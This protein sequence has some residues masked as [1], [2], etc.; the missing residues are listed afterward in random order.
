M[1]VAS[2]AM[3]GVDKDGKLLPWDADPSQYAGH[4]RV[5]A[6]WLPR[7]ERFAR[8]FAQTEPAK[9]QLD[10][11]RFDPVGQHDR[12]VRVYEADLIGPG[13]FRKA[14]AIKVIGGS[15]RSSTLAREARLGGL[16]RHRNHDVFQERYPKYMHSGRD[17]R[18]RSQGQR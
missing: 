4:P 13:G 11:Q 15:E 7:F 1:V 14:V 8:W 2:D 10:I 18:E 16:L 17:R 12:F 6:F 5:A 3:Q 9:P